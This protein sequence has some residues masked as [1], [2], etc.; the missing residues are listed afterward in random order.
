MYKVALVSEYFLCHCL[1]F[2]VFKFY[3]VRFVALTVVSGVQAS[4]M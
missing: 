3:F 2:R 1:K 4:G